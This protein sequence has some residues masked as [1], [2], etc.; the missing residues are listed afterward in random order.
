VVARKFTFFVSKLPPAVALG[1]K[2][3]ATPRRRHRNI[4]ASAI[5]RLG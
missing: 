2:A 3:V 5:N 4:I 1:I